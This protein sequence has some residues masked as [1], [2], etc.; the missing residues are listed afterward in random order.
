[1]SET[2]HPTK[3]Q[4][5]AVVDRFRDYA[6]HRAGTGT[7]TAVV[8]GALTIQREREGCGT[9]ACHG[10]HYCA[11]YVLDPGERI[12]ERATWRA[13]HR[14]GDPT[15]RDTL[16]DARGDAFDYDCGARLM[17]RDL[18]FDSGD[19]L[20]VWADASPEI[21]GN[22]YGG[23]MFFGT[24]SFFHGAGGLLAFAKDDE[25]AAEWSRRCKAGDPVPLTLADV[26]AH[27]ERVRDR[28]PA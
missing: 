10:G 15:L 7:D 21:W 23:L 2:Q 20:T 25:T 6:E 17:A 27:W 5:Q 19:D 11:A 8:M 24:G 9:V 3:A 13:D 22:G 4:V 12:G 1:M 16:F 14:A 28:L 18:G 26:I